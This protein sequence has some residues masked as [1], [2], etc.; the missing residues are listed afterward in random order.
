MPVLILKHPK[1]LH[2]ISSNILSLSDHAPELHSSSVYID[3]RVSC[4]KKLWVWLH[5]F[6]VECGVFNCSFVDNRACTVYL[7]I[8]FV[9]QTLPLVMLSLLPPFPHVPLAVFFDRLPLLHP[10]SSPDIL[11]LHLRT[12]CIFTSGHFA[13]ASLSSGVDGSQLVAIK[14]NICK[15]IAC[16]PTVMCQLVDELVHLGLIPVALQQAIKYPDGKGPYDKADAMIGPIME[17]VCSDPRSIAP[18][19]VEALGKVGLGHVTTESDLIAAAQ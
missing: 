19:L 6:I 9:C 15:A 8:C 7:G 18:A 16:Q 3:S 11:H 10:S 5:A 4:V 13:L 17:R 1:V 14:I 12:F 2:N